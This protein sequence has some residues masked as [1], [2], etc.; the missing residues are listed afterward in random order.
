M[1]RL[2]GR[3]YISIEAEES[4]LGSDVYALANVPK[5]RVRTGCLSCRRR[6]KKC[7]ETKPKCRNCHRNHLRCL[8]P[9]FNSASVDW[10]DPG[11]CETSGLHCSLDYQR[12]RKSEISEG[13]R[14]F[15]RYTAGNV[16]SQAVFTSLCTA[17][18]GSFL[19]LRVLKVHH[20]QGLSLL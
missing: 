17:D 10:A 12:P 18:V 15:L 8:W 20:Q 4:S 3:T 9:G 16:S 19:Q 13:N 1:T 14:T 6:K 7:D 2:P 11:F 5:K